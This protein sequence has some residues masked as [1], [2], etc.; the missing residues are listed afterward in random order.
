MPGCSII[1]GFRLHSGRQVNR[2]STTSRQKRYFSY[3]LGPDY[4]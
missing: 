1:T 2:G 4:F 3:P